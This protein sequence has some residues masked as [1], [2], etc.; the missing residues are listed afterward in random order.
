MAKLGIAL[1]SG[2]RDLG[3]ES[4]H[5]DQEKS[6]LRRAFFNEVSLSARE[7]MLCIVKLLCSEVPEGVGGTLHFTSLCFKETKL[8]Y[9][10]A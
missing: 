4:R 1:G 5:S 6:T 9:A 8:H 7:E 10:V 3:F 2:P